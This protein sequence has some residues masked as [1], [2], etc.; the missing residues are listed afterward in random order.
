MKFSTF[1]TVLAVVAVSMTTAFPVEP[2]QTHGGQKPM[3]PGARTY[4]SAHNRNTAPGGHGH[5]GGHGGHGNHGEHGG[6]GNTGGNGG[7][8]DGF[9]GPAIPSTP[10]TPETPA[11]PASSP[12]PPPGSSISLEETEASAVGNNSLSVGAEEGRSAVSA[13]TENEDNILFGATQPGGAMGF[14]GAMDFSNLFPL[15]S[16]T[17]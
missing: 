15:P 16:P 1:A 3:H 4:P 5:S 11:A 8:P 6:H 10:T 2:C 13:N 9:P 7:N 17:A 14:N 12:V